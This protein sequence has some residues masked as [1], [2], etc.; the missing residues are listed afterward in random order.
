MNRKI[1]SAH[2]CVSKMWE[3]RDVVEWTRSDDEYIMSVGR[4]PKTLTA[5]ALGQVHGV[6]PKGLDQAL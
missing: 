1:V 5:R 3:W 2:Q 4:G 6:D